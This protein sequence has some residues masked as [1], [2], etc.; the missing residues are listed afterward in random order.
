MKALRYYIRLI[1]K[2]NEKIGYIVSWLTTLLVLVV[3]YDVFTRYLLRKSS[4]AIQELEWHLFAV[5]FLLGAAYTLKQDRHVRVDVFYSKF[6]ARGRAWVNLLGG[7]VFLVPF[8]ILVIYTSSDFVINSFLIKETSPDPGG[9]PARYILKACIP[10]GF[11][12]VLLQG[13]SMIFRSILIL[14]GRGLD[15]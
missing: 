9:L 3:C 2:L 1:D 6:S 5:I 4:I 7:L 12:L 11:G 8:S 14:R 15:K 13:I 10:I